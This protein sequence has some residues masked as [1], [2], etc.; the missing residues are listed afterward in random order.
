MRLAI[1]TFPYF[2]IKDT[3]KKVGDEQFFNLRYSNYSLLCF[4]VASL[5]MAT[6]QT[7]SKVIINQSWHKILVDGHASPNSILRVDKLIQ[8]FSSVLI[9]N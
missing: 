5:T 3:R 1:I 2:A 9:R 7:F 6:Q 8:C 4:S